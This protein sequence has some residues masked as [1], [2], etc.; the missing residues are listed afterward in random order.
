MEV[1]QTQNSNMN[2]SPQ[3]FESTMKFSKFEPIDIKPVMGRKWITNG[4]NNKNYKSYQ[5]AYD[6]SPTNASIINAMV[7]FIYGEG[8]IDKGGL[9][10]SQYL[11]KED[12]KLICKDHKLFGGYSI[13]IIWHEKKILKIEYLPVYKL[14]IN[15]TDNLKVNGYW[16]S[17]DWTNYGRYKREFIPIFTGVYKEGQDVEA[18]LI[19]NPTSEPFFPIP[20]YF[21][22]I[23]WCKVEGELSN[24]GIKHFYNSMSA[25]T[26]INYNNG[27]ITDEAVAIEQADKVR[28]KA[29][30]TENQ[31]AVLISFNEGAEESLVVD[32]LHPPELNQ[33]NVF[34]S[35]EAERKIIVGHSA[36][37]ILF[38][39]S[40]NS[41]G[42]SNNADEI[43]IST[44]QLYRRNINPMREVILDGLMKVFKLIDSKYNLDFKNFEEEA[45]ESNG[46]INLPT[47]EVVSLDNK[48][49]EA[50]AQL[51]GSVD[52]KSV[53]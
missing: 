42:F 2:S 11:S 39:G 34:Y 20:D 18:L 19:R 29:V 4:V 28:K 16:Y 8:L 32:Q 10:V 43:A 37:P 14:G 33:Q 7:N 35:E 3:V 27:R 22:C 12:A 25:M 50:Q 13:Q 38:A 24:A 47:T 45:I 48:T 46:V 15:V 21:S 6:D 23:R 26:I 52:R 53:V 9:N 44:K 30:G 51:K 41:N 31:S 49:L 5:D 40:G 17:W 1:N 36:P